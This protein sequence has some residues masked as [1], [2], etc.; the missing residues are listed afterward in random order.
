M[1]RAMKESVSKETLPTVDDFG[2]KQ[3]K[4]CKQKRKRTNQVD[5]RKLMFVPVDSSSQPLSQEESLVATSITRI[6]DKSCSNSTLESEV[7]NSSTDTHS[8]QVQPNLENRIAKSQLKT[9]QHCE[10]ALLEENNSSAAENIQMQSFVEDIKDSQTFQ[11]SHDR[12]TSTTESSLQGTGTT[13]VSLELAIAQLENSVCRMEG[14][15]NMSF[16]HLTC[17]TL[18]MLLTYLWKMACPCFCFHLQG[19]HLST[20]PDSI[21]L[22]SESIT[23]LY[24]QDNRLQ[25]FPSTLC[26]LKKL[27]VLDLSRNCLRYLPEEI[28]NLQNLVILDISDNNLIQ[29]PSSK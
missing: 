7:Q 3:S 18:E 23:H 15:A 28:S 22:F 2:N 25:V 9:K 10:S 24:L 13:E 5:T 27:R 17:T 6:D 1:L 11:E 16:L 14:I 8:T 12:S 29:L 4:L 21:K 20:L 19:N 26:C